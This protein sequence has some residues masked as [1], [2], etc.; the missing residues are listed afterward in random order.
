MTFWNW[1]RGSAGGVAT[2]SAAVAMTGR[3]LAPIELYTADARIVGWIAA[4]G[5]R[6]TDLLNDRMS[7]ALAPEPGPIVAPLGAE[8]RADASPAPT[9]PVSGSRSSP[10]S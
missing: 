2:G 7:C 8:G 6:V 5:Q 9:T 4:N 10:S 3:D 1:R